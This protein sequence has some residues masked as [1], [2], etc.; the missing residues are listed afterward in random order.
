MPDLRV[1]SSG[2]AGAYAFQPLS[3]K[4]RAFVQAFAARVTCVVDDDGAYWFR[5]SLASP[6]DALRGSGLDVV[7]GI[8]PGSENDQPWPEPTN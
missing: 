7:A 6:Y 3:E 2:A 1:R 4:G 8:G 5:D